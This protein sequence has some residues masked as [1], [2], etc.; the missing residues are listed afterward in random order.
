L[1]KEKTDR[2]NENLYILAGKSN[3]LTFDLV[4]QITKLK[5]RINKLEE[6]VRELENGK[7]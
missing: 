3:K 6:K 5:L 2:E 1:E 4:E 7:G